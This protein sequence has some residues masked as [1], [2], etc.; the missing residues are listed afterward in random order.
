MVKYRSVG[1][2]VAGWQV[3]G[4]PAVEGWHGTA[5]GGRFEAVS[6]G[7]ILNADVLTKVVLDSVPVRA[8]LA[9][10]ALI[11]V[12]ARVILADAAF[13][14]AKDGLVGAFLVEDVWADVPAKAP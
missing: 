3:M 6:G 7:V 12:L 11:G 8:A 14:F 5:P 2:T 4:C 9:R 1:R 13:V 10:A